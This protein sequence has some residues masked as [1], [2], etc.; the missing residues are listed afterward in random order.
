MAAT[1]HN[2]LGQS[3]RTQLLATFAEKEKKKMTHLKL[4]T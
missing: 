1:T 2:G 4:T 3:E